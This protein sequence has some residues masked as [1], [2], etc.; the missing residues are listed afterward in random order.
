MGGGRSGIVVAARSDSSPDHVRSRH[1]GRRERCCENGDRV[2]DVGTRIRPRPPS[3]MWLQ[4]RR[5]SGL[6]PCDVR[7]IF[8]Y[9]ME[10]LDAGD[11]ARVGRFVAET[12]SIEGD[13]PFP[14]EFLAAIRRLVPCDS[15]AFYELDRI[16]RSAAAWV[17][18]GGAGRGRRA[19]AHYWEA[20]REH[21]ICRSTRRPATG[22]RTGFRTSSRRAAPVAPDL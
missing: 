20:R 19:L 17:G 18:P 6:S 11:L 8:C 5:Y 1:T 16:G 7:R 12:G 9:E 21:P 3:R 13:E 15:V 22:G 4:V 14:T 2:A 10:R